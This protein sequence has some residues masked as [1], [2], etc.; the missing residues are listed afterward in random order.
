ML[1]AFGCP[2]GF[3]QCRQVPS[4]PKRGPY[5]GAQALKAVIPP[6]HELETAH[7]QVYEQSSPYL[8]AHGI[9][10]ITE[11]VGKLER[12]LHLFEEYLDVPPAAVEL[13]DRPRAPLL[14]VGQEDHLDIL[15]VELHEGYNA[16][17]LARVGLLRFF[18]HQLDDFVAKDALVLRR[19][20]RDQNHG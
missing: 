1:C 8:P 16:A 10:A 20:I 9:G 2:I 18:E 12:L 17:Q 3:N 4:T 15:S 11:E 7:Q 14:M 6:V 19:H 13:R 5:D